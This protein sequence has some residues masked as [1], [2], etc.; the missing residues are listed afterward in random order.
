M[1][2]AEEKT[3][4]STMREFGAKLFLQ[5]GGQGANWLPEL[6]KAYS[7]PSTKLFFEVALKALKEEYSTIEGHP[8][9]EKGLP[10]ESWLADPKNFADDSYLNRTTISMPMIQLTQL[11]NVEL[12]H[13]ENLKRSDF[14]PLCQGATGHSQGLATSTLL[15]LS[16]Q[17]DEYYQFVQLYMKFLFW[18]GV[19]SQET[20]P[21][22]EPGEEELALATELNLDLPSPMTA[23]LH[24]ESAILA[25]LVARFN[26]GKE[27]QYHLYISLKNTPTNSILSGPRKSL[28]DFYKLNR[29]TLSAGDTDFV[30]LRASC[31]YH[32][33]HM[34]SL[35]PEFRK[36]VERIGFHV[37]GKDLK[38]P[39][40]STF[41]RHNLQNDGEISETI[42]FDIALRPVDWIGVVSP[43]ENQTI[44][45]DFG[46]A[47]VS[48]RFTKEILEHK[49][50]EV[51]ALSTPADR[52]KLNSGK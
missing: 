39:V 45:L 6:A 25:D 51:L 35:I 14:F 29:S 40:Y 16:L 46:P 43:L 9:F 49:Q 10:V 3:E 19:R 21:T 24:L 1:G 31:P 32:S 47:K 11:A 13:Q 52:K 34:G 42:M 8:L 5:F 41:D 7:N 28:L 36:D 4:I 2:G 22:P 20:F 48:Q 27:E 50:V 26:E 18:L 38:F 23:V 17:D 15:A 44:V 33:P 30:F 37:Y 12:V